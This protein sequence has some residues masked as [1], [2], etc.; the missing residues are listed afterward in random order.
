MYQIFHGHGGDRKTFEA[1]TSIYAIGILGSVGSLLAATLYQENTGRNH[2]LTSTAGLRI[3]HIQ[4]G[5]PDTLTY[6]S[7]L[8]VRGG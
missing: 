3:R 8:T 6:T 1:M 4:L 5:L 7:T 2:R